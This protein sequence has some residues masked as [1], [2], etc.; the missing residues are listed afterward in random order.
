MFVLRIIADAESQTV[1][2]VLC[3]EV[4]MIGPTELIV[5]ISCIYFPICFG[6]IASKLG[7]NG[8]L[9]GLLSIIPVVN[10]FILGILAFSDKNLQS[11][12]SE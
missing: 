9:F 8:L 7:R 5:L 1:D 6:K 4:F 3:K 11:K 2:L 10:L 12:T